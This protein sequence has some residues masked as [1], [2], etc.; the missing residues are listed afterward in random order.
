MCKALWETAI[1][2]QEEDKNMKTSR[3]NM[4]EQEIRE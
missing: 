3:Q 1:R 4:I 2:M